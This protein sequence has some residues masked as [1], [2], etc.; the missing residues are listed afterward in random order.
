MKTD[1]EAIDRNSL[2]VTLINLRGDGSVKCSAVAGC[3]RTAVTGGW[4]ITQG[5]D[6]NSFSVC[7]HHLGTAGQKKR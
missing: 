7:R 6:L 4:H 5:Q 3:N 1:R 2:G